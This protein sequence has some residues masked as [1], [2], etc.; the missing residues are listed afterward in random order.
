M[1]RRMQR[2]RTRLGHVHNA[3]S[4]KV[5]GVRSRVATTLSSMRRMSFAYAGFPTLSQLHEGLQDNAGEPAEVSARFMQLR[6]TVVRCVWEVVGEEWH[7]PALHQ[8]R[9]S[10]SC[11]AASTAG[12]CW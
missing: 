12:R 2:L 10:T 9:P 5:G 8:A 1:G 11:C 7:A 3:Y 4:S 6:N